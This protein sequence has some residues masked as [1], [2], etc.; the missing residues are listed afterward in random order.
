[1]RTFICTPYPGLAFTV[2]AI[3]NGDDGTITFEIEV[4]EGNMD[5]NALYLSDGNEND[6]YAGSDIQFIGDPS[7]GTTADWNPED[8]PN[9]NMNGATDSDGNPIV[10]DVGVKLTDPGIT[11]EDSPTFIDTD[12]ATDS[13]DT[14]EF[15]VDAD[16][17]GIDNLAEFNDIMFIGLRGTSSS[18]TNEGEGGGTEG[19][20]KWV[21]ESEPNQVPIAGLAQS[22]VS[23]EGFD[24]GI[25]DGVGYGGSFPPDDLTNNAIDTG[26]I[27][28]SDPD[29][30]PLSIQLTTPIT[31]IVDSDGNVININDLSSGGDPIVWELTDDNHTLIGYVDNNSSTMFDAGDTEVIKIQIEDGDLSNPSS[32]YFGNGVDTNGD[33]TPDALINSGD[34]LVTLLGPL[35][36]PLNSVEDLIFFDVNYTVDDGNGGVSNG[37]LT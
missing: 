32:G 20:L 22:V 9:L 18:N 4:T 2:T 14:L 21:G 5:V 34:Y 35:D 11:S 6:D 1:M 36:H 17:L 16:E 26:S 19:S 15:T 3:W 27:D 28:A 12:P 8:D 10:W 7:A 33:L 13:P 29:G 24:D 31:N 25:P 23:E 30:D 37:T